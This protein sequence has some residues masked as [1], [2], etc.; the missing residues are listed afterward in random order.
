[1]PTNQLGKIELK[2]KREKIQNTILQNTKIIGHLKEIR[3]EKTSFTYRKPSSSE[4]FLL[5]TV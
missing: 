4:K 1:M 3:E 2:N 5:T